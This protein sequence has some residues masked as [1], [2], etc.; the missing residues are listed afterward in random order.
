MIG[1]LIMLPFAIVTKVISFVMWIFKTGI[2]SV[3]GIFKFFFGRI[4]GILF[5][6]LIGLFLGGSGVAI[7]MPWSKKKKK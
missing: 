3:L 7:K 2:G 1:K 5:G 6:A 4:F